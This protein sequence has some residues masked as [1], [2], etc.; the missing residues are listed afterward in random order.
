MT[1]VAVTYTFHLD[2]SVRRGVKGI[3]TLDESYC[4]VSPIRNEEKLNF[5]KIFVLFVH[6]FS[7]LTYIHINNF[8]INS[9]TIFILTVPI[10]HYSSKFRASVN[11]TIFCTFV[12]I[13]KHKLYIL[14]WVITNHNIAKPSS[15]VN[16][17]IFIIC[18]G[19]LKPS[20][21]IY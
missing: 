3:F 6:I 12:V 9:F 8:K 17:N 11:S 13:K 4:A 10:F 5:I 2:C 1:A 16:E 18:Y 20:R 15:T 19:K 7:F 21:N 14:T